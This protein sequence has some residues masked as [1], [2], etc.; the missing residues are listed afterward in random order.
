[1]RCF[2]FFRFIFFYR[3]KY[4]NQGIADYK[5]IGAA[6]IMTYL[7]GENRSKHLRALSPVW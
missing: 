2:I 7:Y 4:K 3:E 1:M 5:R 6:W